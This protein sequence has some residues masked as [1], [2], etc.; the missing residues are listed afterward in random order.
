M[1]LRQNRLTHQIAVHLS[2][3]APPFVDGPDHQALAAAHI[4]RSKHALDAGGVLSVRP[5]SRSSAGLAPRQVARSGCFRDPGSPSPATPVAPATPFRCRESLWDR[6][7]PL[8]PVTHST[9]TVCNSFTRPFS[10]PTNFCV[11]MQID[12]GVGTVTGDGFLLAV[13]D[14]SGFWAIPA[15]DYPAGARQGGSGRISNCV[16]DLQPCR[17]EVPTQSVP[18]SPPPITI[19]SRPS[20][21]MKSGD[22]RGAVEHVLGVGCEEFHGEMNAIQLPAGDRQIAGFRRPAAQHDSVELFGQLLRWDDPSP[23]SVLTTNSTPS[24]AIRSTRRCTMVLSSFM[25]G[26]PYISRPPMRSA[27]SYTVT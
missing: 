19:T 24:A 14:A 4:A 5:L 1:L 6:G 21:E 3:C 2:R 8:L 26:M 22:G 12:A 11:M 7:R 13:I 20:A 25:L 23:T 27:R 15:R 18:V 10:S 17:S 16:R 9:S